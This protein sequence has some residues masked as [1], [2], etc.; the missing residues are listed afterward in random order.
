MHPRLLR[1]RIPA[2]WTLVYNK[3]HEVDSSDV[4]DDDRYYFLDEDLLLM[5]HERFKRLL[6]VGWYPSGNVAD[7]AYR[8]VVHEGDARGKLV[9]EH[10][11]PSRTQLVA[12]V[13]RL[14]DEVSEGR[15][16]SGGQ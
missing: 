9:A 12:E 1:L 3:L 6:D 11:T 14:L 5:H 8:I 4:L 2:G 16:Q 13:E 10:R 7:G 15:M